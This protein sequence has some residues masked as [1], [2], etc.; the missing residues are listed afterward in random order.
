MTRRLQHLANWQVIKQRT[1]AVSSPINIALS[2]AA[3]LSAQDIDMLC[4]SLDRG[5]DALRRAAGGHRELE[6]F[7][8]AVVV[9]R[10]IEKT[11]VVRCLAV[12]ISC[13][14]ALRAIRARQSAQ[15]ADQNTLVLRR[16]EILS[17]DEFTA[18]P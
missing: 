17:I 13:D 3:K 11:G 8:R 12:Q 14:E 5:L 16:L 7:E 15:D 4:G 6:D 10:M 9:A 2:R 18:D 1:K